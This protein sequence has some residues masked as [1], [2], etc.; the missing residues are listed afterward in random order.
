DP[1]LVVD[2]GFQLSFAA[3][4]GIV[5][6]AL[7]A[8]AKLRSIGQWNPSPEHPHPPSCST[9]TRIFAE[10]LFWNEREFNREMARS[11]VR[12]KLDKV[13]SARSLNRWG[14][15]PLFRGVVLLVM[16]SAA[17]QLATLPLMV[18]YFNRAAPVGLLLNVVA[19][20]LTGVLMVSSVLTLAAGS[21]SVWL[22]SKLAWVV[23]A[24]HHLLVNSIVPF[25]PIAVASFR[26]P[27]Y[28]GLGT[29]V[30][31]VYFAPLALLAILIDRWRPVNR[32][33]AVEPLAGRQEKKNGEKIVGRAGRDDVSVRVS[34]D[35]RLPHSR[36]GQFCALSLAAAIVAVIRPVAPGPSGKLS[37]SFLDVG[38]GDSALVVFPQGATM[39]IDG[40]GEIHIGARSRAA[41]GEDRSAPDDEDSEETEPE[42]RDGGLTIGE[43]VVS[44]FLWSRG[45][46]RLDYALATHAHSDHIAGLRDVI[47][48]FG[49][50]ELIVGHA[51]FHDVEFRR[52][53]DSAAGRRVVLGT[54]ASGDRF[55]VD[56][57][58]ID[59]LWP[60]PVDE[61]DV[62]SG[63]NDSVVLRIAYGSVSFVMAGDLE[64]PGE[65]ALVESGTELH[66]DVLKVGHHGSKTSSTDAFLD[67]VQPEYAIISVGER[68][69]FGHPHAEVVQRYLARGIKLSQTGRDGM[70]TAETD[71]KTL[72][73]KLFGASP[74]KSSS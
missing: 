57:V 33:I 37:I 64:S 21:I 53:A 8:I 5:A 41:P 34:T 36:L 38:Q 70:I 40:G 3:V 35:H 61:T 60:K 2:P 4:G 56:G 52:L 14:V 24:A 9:L 19:G 10:W 62:R 66:A 48:N 27:Q 13:P 6:L 23:V 47:Q 45:L 49:L 69:R 18:L 42:F 44:R 30:Y 73:V 11:Q 51:P 7:P 22:A 72:E 58:Q 63:N 16:T 55:E 29:I 17:I 59:V 39:L 32:M 43:A 12:Y 68:S 71:G 28:D 46:R 67:R 26:A 20:L 25:E 1:T 31:A 74:A 54:V 15:Q 65:S 50:G